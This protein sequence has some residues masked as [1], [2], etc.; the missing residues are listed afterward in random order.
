MFER[1]LEGNSKVSF[2]ETFRYSHE[3]SMLLEKKKH[4]IRIAFD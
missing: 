4:K 2:G 3:V 1:Q